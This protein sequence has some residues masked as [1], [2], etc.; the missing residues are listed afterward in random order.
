M[1]MNAGE[2]G[3]G[4]GDDSWVCGHCDGD[5]LAWFDCEKGREVR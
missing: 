2:V 4:G 1:A 3:F 5:V